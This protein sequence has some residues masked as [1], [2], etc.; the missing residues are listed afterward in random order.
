MPVLFAT[1]HHLFLTLR[2]VL[3]LA[4]D[5]THPKGCP[6]V[7]WL[8]PCLRV[9]ISF[10]YSRELHGDACIRRTSDGRG[11]GQFAL[12]TL[13]P[14]WFSKFD[15]APIPGDKAC[16]GKEWCLALGGGRFLNAHRRAKR[17]KRALAA[18]ADGQAHYAACGLAALANE[19]LAGE[20]ANA[21]FVP[22]GY[23]VLARAVEIGEEITVGYLG[24]YVRD[25]D[26]SRRSPRGRSF[27][28]Y[29][30][31]A[32]VLIGWSSGS[33]SSSRNPH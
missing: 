9:S 7:G 13:P 32:V 15:G 17:A 16:I 5:A 4:C 20:T 30:A 26:V 25:Y 8:T 19:P 2:N 24:S 31:V 33:D 10:R 18:A 28:A 3:R 14:G 27:Q 12:R 22:E 23:L 21:S 1:R 11:V 29:G 6:I